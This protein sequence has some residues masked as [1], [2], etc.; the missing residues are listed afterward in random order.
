MIVEARWGGVIG[1]GRTLTPPKEY[2]L[3][4]TTGVLAAVVRE[5][6]LHDSISRLK[7]TVWKR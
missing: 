7:L 4:A 2:A 1:R 5:L 3:P 6:S